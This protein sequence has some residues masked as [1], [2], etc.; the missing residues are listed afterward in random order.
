[1]TD[2]AGVPFVGREAALAQLRATL[3]TTG[4]LRVAAVGGEPGV[5]K[6]RLSMEF[7]AVAHAEGAIV[8][9]GR[10]D[11]EAVVPYQP[12]AEALRTYVS[13]VPAAAGLL[14]AAERLLGRQA[15]RPDPDP[16]LERLALF[17]GLIEF[18]AGVGRA[19][20]LVLVLDD[21]H[22]ADAPTLALLR[23]LCRAPAPIPGLVVATYRDSELARTHP[24]A[25]TLAELRREHAVERVP[26]SGL[27]R[28]DV[29][30]M[31]ERASGHPAPAAFVRALHDE[32]EGNPFFIEEIVRHLIESG[33]IVQREGRWTSDRSI[34]DMQIPEG[35]RE[36]V[37]RRLARLSDAANRALTQAAVLG[38]RFEF[39]VL[40]EMAEAGEDELLDALDEALA[41]QLVVEVAGERATYAFRHAL[42]RETLYA[43]LSLPRRQRTHL[44]AADAI[45]RVAGAAADEH[46]S[47]IALH[48]RT[49][50][51]AANARRALDWTLRAAAAH[52]AALAW[53]EASAQLEAALE[54]VDDAG[55]E[56]LER[57][58]I[59]ERLADLRYVTNVDVERGIAGL[60]E[61]LACY[62]EAGSEERAA[63]IHS[64]LARDLATYWG[65]NDIRR[66]AH[67]VEQ[68]EAIVGTTAHDQLVAMVNIARATVEMA[69]VDVPAI[70]VAA[71]RAIDIANAIGRPRIALNAEILDAWAAGLQAEPDAIAR[72]DRAWHEADALNHPWLA[73]LVT[74]VAVPLVFWCDSAERFQEFLDRE[75]ASPRSEAAPGQRRYLGSFRAEAATAAGRLD[76]ADAL[77][78][79]HP[80]PEFPMADMFQA[81]WRDGPAA[82]MRLAERLESDALAGGNG[83]TYAMV[84]LWRGNALAGLPDLTASIAS[85]LV[86]IEEGRRFE[87]DAFA[88]YEGGVL[89]MRMVR[90][91]RVDE[92][93]EVLAAARRI[94]LD[95]R[96]GL[97]HDR[98]LAGEAALAAVNGDPA[99]GERLAA[100]ADAIDARGM[101]YLAAE[102]RRA[103]GVLLGRTEPI[104]RALDTYVSTG[105]A[106][107]WVELTRSERDRVAGAPARAAT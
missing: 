79:Q 38:R 36:A 45:E 105:V 86:S 3:A 62:R 101:V 47:T 39:D 99:A 44:R 97:A 60:E 92:A 71:Q 82:A 54:L 49:A 26:L 25:A 10:C 58:A 53:E 41:A 77:L 16:T 75:L 102:V 20:P 57:A 87:A 15:T 81:M 12:F 32:T 48:L 61:A 56:P 6:T 64:R 94:V 21:L 17:D 67:H 104:D 34:A 5:G 74:W 73:F 70:R 11:E 52:A 59:H 88:G 19:G 66:A 22:W 31:L 51:A 100:A 90:A 89:G 8:L 43:E 69:R 65:T 50:G 84:A 93:R 30:A 96:W 23:H 13:A 42:V 76:E 83:W 85:T 103:H 18:L 35:V 91:G 106:E 40:A 2:D 78:A 9:F 46:A 107:S 29:A 55:S 27:A 95:G 7:A 14:G 98:L 63:R 28:E 4:R 1:V 33:A 72:L 68:A 37:G 80:M 24:L